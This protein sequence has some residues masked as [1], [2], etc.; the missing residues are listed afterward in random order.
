MKKNKSST[1]ALSA[2]LA[3]LM[4]LSCFAYF[5]FAASN[6]VLSVIGSEAAPGDLVTVT[7]NMSGNPGIAGMSV[8][9]SF[10]NSVLTP[11]SAS[12]GSALVGK[13]VTSNF[14]DPSADTSDLDTIF[15]QLVSMKNV[16]TNGAFFTITFKVKDG[17][18]AALSAIRIN[19]NDA[20]NQDLDDVYVNTTNGAV[21]ILE[22]EEDDK[23]N[24]DNKD[25][26]DLGQKAEIKLR[27]KASKIKYMVGR[28]DK[29]EPDEYATRYEV[30]ECLYNLFDI[31]LMVDDDISF[32]DVDAKHNAMVKLFAA[33]GVING[34]TDNTFRGNNTIKRS[35][36]CVLVTALLDLDLGRARD[37]GFTDVKDKDWFAPY[38]N[39]CAREGLVQGKGNNRFAPNANI[40]RAE[41]ATLINRITG[42]DVDSATSCIY[43]DVDPDKWYFGQV[44]AAAK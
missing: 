41:V 19:C 3:V 24:E 35:E 17:S 14:D 12:A 26:E 36:F 7:I 38:V 23:K 29:F 42:A 31:D 28:G 4:C 32:K 39:I 21:T 40:T 5:T 9:V 2:L 22:A 44:A 8:D 43:P 33:A 25:D 1:K 34:Y 20:A 18:D 16:T 10:D 37:Q 13:G 15:F 30:V 6:P 27:N 11:V